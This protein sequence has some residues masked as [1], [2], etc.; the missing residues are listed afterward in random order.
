[1]I[2]ITKKIGD[3]LVKFVSEGRSVKED[4]L[5]ITWL[6]SAPT[7][8][9]ICNSPNIFLEG[10]IA[11]NQEG[12]EFTYCSYKCN[13]CFSSATLGEYKKGGLFLKNWKKYEKNE[14]NVNNQKDNQD[15][16]IPF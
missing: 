16:S 1:M 15:D 10:H 14:S 9:K 7:T 5:N 12:E 13:D 11:K 4:I 8:C 6:T 3:T 2:E